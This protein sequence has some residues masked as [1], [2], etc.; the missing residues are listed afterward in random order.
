M[1]FQ[2]KGTPSIAANIKKITKLRP[3][4]IMEDTFFDKRKMYLGTL[5]FVKM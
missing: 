4:L 1:N 2:V 3:K 5:I